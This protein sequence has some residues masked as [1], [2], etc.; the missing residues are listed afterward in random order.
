MSWV[1]RLKTGNWC[2][3]CNKPSTASNP[4]SLN[5]KLKPVH[6][7]KLT[8]NESFHYKDNSRK[9]TQNTIKSSSHHPSSKPLKRIL[10]SWMPKLRDSRIRSH[11]LRIKSFSPEEEV[12]RI[13][14]KIPINFS[15]ESLIS[16]SKEINY[17]T[18]S[19]L[20]PHTKND[21]KNSTMMPSPRTMNSMPI[22][23]KS[24]SKTTEKSWNSSMKSIKNNH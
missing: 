6:S 23:P 18:D 12:I 17:L 24:T 2:P 22:S 1:S 13:T 21:S 19:K 5:S 20:K 3:P 9:W 4:T 16:R 14:P 7:K 8:E 15:S 10:K 11:N